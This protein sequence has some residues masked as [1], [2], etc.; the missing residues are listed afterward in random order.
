M[1]NQNASVALYIYILHIFMFNNV[2]TFGFFSPSSMGLQS[3]F[4]YI[5]DNPVTDENYF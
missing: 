3:P 4:H 5:T 1:F 2:L